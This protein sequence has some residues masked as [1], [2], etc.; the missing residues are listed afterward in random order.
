MRI[1]VG[2][3]LQLA[4]L[5][6]IQP[7]EAFAVIPGAGPPEVYKLLVG[8]DGYPLAQPD[9]KILAVKLGTLFHADHDAQA[10][11][12]NPD[13]MVRRVKLTLDVGA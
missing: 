13:T 4:G 8:S 11:V 3:S 9:G 5:D 1:D 7:G 6:T 10:V 12:F 2:G